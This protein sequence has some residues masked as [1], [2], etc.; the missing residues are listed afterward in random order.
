MN[1]YD[2]I[3][4]GGSYAGLSAAMALGRALRS[5]L[6][7]DAGKPCNI[8]T[9]HSHNF[10]TQD[11][12]APLQIAEEARQQVKQYNT[13]SFKKAFAIK[14]D[15]IIKG[16]LFTVTTETGETY[17][18]NKLILAMGVKDILPNIKGFKECWGISAIHCPYCHGYEVRDQETGI[19]A[20][21]DMAFEFAKLI[22]NWTDKL[23]VYTNGTSTISSEQQ[24]KLNAKGIKINKKS[25]AE[26]V[27]NNGHLQEL[28]FTDGSRDALTALYA[29]PQTEQHTNIPA[30]LGCEL[31]DMGLIST[32][33]MQKT[34]VQGI[35]AAGDCTTM[36]RSVS[37]AVSTGSIAGAA[38]NH[39]L[40]DDEF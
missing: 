11:G 20:N 39:E 13:V 23:T 38:I 18:A 8:Q 2:V 40:I 9:P 12:K 31:D 14:A 22:N 37:I 7:I 3:I 17:S 32:D 10:I 30:L 5:V 33:V 26:L 35:Y 16:K 1:K 21:G 4:I 25:I 24:E 36:F 27:H 19:L 15:I 34:N 29:R 6:V 28:L